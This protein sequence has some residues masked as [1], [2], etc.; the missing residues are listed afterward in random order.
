MSMGLRA[1]KLQEW[2]EIDE[3]FAEEL[4]LKDKLLKNQYSD[5]FASLPESK[6]SQREVLDLLLISNPVECTQYNR[7]RATT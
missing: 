1:L 4:A 2:I 3:H 7:R 5:V 6:P